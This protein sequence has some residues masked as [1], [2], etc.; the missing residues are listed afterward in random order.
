MV[1]REGGRRGGEGG[2]QRVCVALSHHFHRFNRKWY[3]NSISVLQCGSV[4]CSVH[5]KWYRNNINVR[6][7]IIGSKH[8]HTEY[9][10]YI[11]VYIY[12]EKQRYTGYIICVCIYIHIYTCKYKYMY[13]HTCIY[14]YVYILK[15]HQENVQ[16]QRYTNI[17]A[18]EWYPSLGIHI[19]DVCMYLY[20]YV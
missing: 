6:F 3:W 5:R 2:R 9:F 17:W 7:Q 12:D 20:T 18:V 11:H 14:I 15:T 4:C 8:G 10:V 1:A 13:M 19:H 16:K